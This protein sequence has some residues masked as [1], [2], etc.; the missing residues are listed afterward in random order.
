LT[1]KTVTDPERP[2]AEA[3]FLRHLLNE[4]SS[5]PTA[6]KPAYTF[7]DAV[8]AYV[9]EQTKAEAWTLKSQ[10][11]VESTLARYR[12]HCADKSLDPFAKATA[13]AYKTEVLVGG[14]LQ[15]NTINKYLGRLSAF[16]GW[17]Q[18]NGYAPANILERT[19]ISN[20]KTK[21]SEERDAYTAEEIGKLLAALNPATDL[22][23]WLPLLG[24]YT[25]A[26][27]NEL[28]QLRLDDIKTDPESG[29]V[30]ID[31]NDDTPGKRIKNAN[32]RRVVP[33]H[34]GLVD[35]GF[36]KHVEAMRQ[37]GQQRLFPMWSNHPSN[38][39]GHYASKWYREH[40]LP[41]QVGIVNPLAI[42]TP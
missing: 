4:T 29:V 22:K 23:H 24:L 25:G 30:Y 40:F 16:F 38:G 21:K 35:M 14:G 20:R 12:K 7:T 3:A 32:S 28:A 1:S 26:R 42:L 27:I 6:S 5:R 10:Q 8:T 36:V 11:E 37:A 19:S 17:C 15:V 41:K 9:R 13:N 33:L 34:P 18:R 31:I 39:P 2:E